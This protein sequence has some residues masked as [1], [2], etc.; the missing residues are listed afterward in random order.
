MHSD[1]E[2]AEGFPVGWLRDLMKAARPPVRSFGE[3]AR[4]ALAHPDWPKGS[5]PQ[6]RSLAALFSKLDRDQELDWLADR[7]GVQQILAQ[8][9][10]RPVN[11]IAARV[12]LSV[13]PL[14]PEGDRYRLDE[15][16]YARPLSLLRESLCPGFPR[17]VSLPGSWHHI[18]WVAEPGSRRNL[19]ATWLATRGLCHVHESAAKRPPYDLPT[20][21]AVFVNVDAPDDPILK[22]VAEL[23]QV[24][25]AAPFEPPRSN[26]AEW[27]L[28]RS[29]HPQ[30]YL[31]EL[32]L[33]VA[34][35]L[36]EESGFDAG[37]ASVWLREHAIGREGFDSLEAV[38][39]LCGALEEVGLDKA[40]RGGLELLTESY[41]SERLSQ[42]RSQDT[43]LVAWLRRRGLK[44]LID[45]VARLFVDGSGPWDAPRSFDDWLDLVPLEHQMSGDV[46]W[47]RLA[48]AGGEHPVRPGDIARAAK[49]MPPGA[50]RVIRGLE[51]CG[52]LTRTVRGDYT[53]G[54]RWFGISVSKLARR[55]LL[56]SSPVE[57]GE[58]LLNP[59]ETSHS[60]V[61]L[62]RLCQQQEFGPVESALELEAEH[63]PANTACL[64]AGFVA[65]G[66]A[67]LGGVDAPHELVESIWN[68]QLGLLVELQA[69]LPRQ[70]LICNR[71]DAP[72]GRD[73]LVTPGAF[74][75]AA[76][77]L[78]E[79]LP[80]QVGKRHALLAPWHQAS[81]PAL[82]ARLYD[83]MESFVTSSRQVLDIAGPAV[84][85]VDRLR[86]A[87]GLSGPSLHAL[88]LAGVI[89]DEV[90]HEV[91]TAD[92]LVQLDA[93]AHGV[94]YLAA[95]VERRG[96]SW[97]TVAQALWQA[98]CDGG[99]S[100]E[101]GRLFRLD[102]VH[103]HALWRHIPTGLLGELLSGRVDVPLHGDL[104]FPHFGE[105]QWQVVVT[106]L[107][108]GQAARV[109]ASAWQE[110][111]KPC[112]EQLLV[113]LPWPRAA[114]ALPFLW[115]RFASELTARAEQAA[116][117]GRALAVLELIEGA[118]PEHTSVLVSCLERLPLLDLKRAA[119][120]RLR[121]WLLERCAA[122]QAGWR[123][124]YA[125]LDRLEVAVLPLRTLPG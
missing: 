113:G 36:P 50:F 85:L 26:S 59:E 74:Y 61:E 79:Q 80:K 2:T 84:A 9:L 103:A 48:L 67:E 119:F 41:F 104:G 43:A 116:H 71:T 33:W 82:L 4:Q 40:A 18:W 3:L 69:E 62:T 115:R 114:E 42:S 110:L 23:D 95:L 111:P 66:L 76:L 37:R 12:Q 120:D 64:E 102:A 31:N 6:P 53:L 17:D 22:T 60:V 21:S 32:T 92:A 45:L 8:A 121:R 100:H 29:P 107:L 44:V 55:E 20:R 47:M 57:W 5:V 1:A 81:P 24:C 38:L 90:E 106:A 88:E 96:L 75:L 97:A 34:A 91:L 16:P 101:T 78:S 11:D 123:E 72:R 83:E 118:P 108:A 73:S 125:L 7:Q 112:V 94:E 49:R 10:G 52:L 27:R 65:L 70:R 19:V 93:A 87:I 89:L 56:R 63:D 58:A 124:A 14:S 54:P 98:W 68:E 15:V 25:V 77:A 30:T 86:N 51:Q 122:R 28:V 39:G 105:E 117:E 46:E 13:E 99:H 109:T 35:R